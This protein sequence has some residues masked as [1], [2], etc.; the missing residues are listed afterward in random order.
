M[1]W[2][3]DTKERRRKSALRTLLS[4]I[5]CTPIVLI[6]LYICVRDINKCLFLLLGIIAATIYYAIMIYKGDWI[7]RKIGV[8]DD[9][10][11][12]V[13]Y[14]SVS[15]VM[16]SLWIGLS[17]CYFGFGLIESGITSAISFCFASLF[18]GFLTLL[19]TDVF[20]NN[21]RL[22]LVE[23][24]FGNRYYKEVLGYHPGFF[25][26][27]LMATATLLGMCLHNLLDSIFFS[28]GSLLINMFCVFLSLFVCYLA[29]S[30]HIVNKFLP[31]ENRTPEGL[32]KF[33]MIIL[34]IT[35]ISGLFV[36]DVKGF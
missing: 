28:S 7:D 26:V 33:F 11:Y 31:F 17:I 15:V 5:L 14:Q 32:F 8:Y 2:D 22:L 4:A 35:F 34:F 13:S 29:V 27:P 24:E 1:S 21:S 30:P 10:F 20:N 18:V 36:I 25:W 12:G 23:D 16:F 6:T 9:D 19:R 3:I